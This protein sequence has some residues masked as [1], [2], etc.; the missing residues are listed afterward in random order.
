MNCPNCGTS[1]LDTASICANCGRPLSGAGA[2]PPPPPPPQASYTP[3]QA[4]YTPPPPGSSFGAQP[5]M[6]IPN[7]LWQAI[8]VTLCCCLPLGIVGIIFAAQ[9]NDKLRAGDVAGA[10]A[11]S[12]NAKTWTLVGFI[13]GIVWVAIIC[14]I[15]GAAIISAINS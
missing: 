13:C 3:P 10:M 9:V 6:Q 12:K 11:A 8:V 15:Y 4:S 2:V 5:P 7:Y 1:N 14:V